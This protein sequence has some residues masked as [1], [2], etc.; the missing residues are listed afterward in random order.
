M[1]TLSKKILANLGMNYEKIDVCEHNC[2]LLW[3]EH[4]EKTHCIHIAVT[5][6]S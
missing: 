2:V 3:K 6:D 4:N 5:L 1:R